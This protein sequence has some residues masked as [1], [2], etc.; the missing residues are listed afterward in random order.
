[1]HHRLLTITNASTCVFDSSLFLLDVSLTIITCSSEFKAFDD[2]MMW[3]TKTSSG[4]DLAIFYGKQFPMNWAGRRN[5]TVTIIT[6]CKCYIIT[7]ITPCKCYIQLYLNVP[8]PVETRLLQY[9]SADYLNKQAGSNVFDN[10]LYMKF[11]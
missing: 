9:G 3:Q 11:L 4:W 5:Q 10:L 7:I 6:P 1:M 2:K 8:G